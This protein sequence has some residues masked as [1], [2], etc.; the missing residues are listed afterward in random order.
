MLK[1]HLRREEGQ[2]ADLHP[3]FSKQM[4]GKAEQHVG[5]K[6]LPEIGQVVVHKTHLLSQ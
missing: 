3:N 1:V 5:D 4:A 6:P 2:G